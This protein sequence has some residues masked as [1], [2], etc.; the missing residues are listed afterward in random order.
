MSRTQNIGKFSFKCTSTVFQEQGGGNATPLPA[1]LPEP[2]SVMIWD[3]DCSPDIQP[4]QIICPRLYCCQL[5][6]EI[7]CRPT[8]HKNQLRREKSITHTQC[9]HLAGPFEFCGRIFCQWPPIRKSP[10]LLPT[11]PSSIYLHI[12]VQEPQGR[13]TRVGFLIGSS[14]D[15]PPGTAAGSASSPSGNHSP[16]PVLF[17][18]NQAVLRI[19]IRRIHMF[20]GLPDPHPDP[21]VSETDPDQDPPIIKQK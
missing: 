10:I 5:L 19:R 13:D 9:A 2:G 7:A 14:E 17:L 3:G 12:I 1:P 8:W 4:N 16:G 6:T 20:L 18:V 15:S 21:L 11:T